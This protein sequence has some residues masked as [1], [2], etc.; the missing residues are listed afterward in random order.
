MNCCLPWGQ[1]VCL[2]SPEEMTCTVRSNRPNLWFRLIEAVEEHSGSWAH[3]GLGGQPAPPPGRSGWG[4]PPRG[5]LRP[6]G[7]L[8]LLDASFLGAKSR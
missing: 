1:G 7:S 5:P 4:G 3:L 2:Y 6:G 8:I